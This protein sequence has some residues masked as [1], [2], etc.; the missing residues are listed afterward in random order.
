[1]KTIV[2]ILLIT[3]PFNIF[4]QELDINPLKKHKKTLIGLNFSP[5][6]S[7]RYLTGGSSYWTDSRNSNENPNFNFAL[8]LNI[9]HQIHHNIDL[10]F[11]VQYSKNGYSSD[12]RPL[13]FGDLLGNGFIIEDSHS[14]SNGKFT[15][16]YNYL[17]LPIRAIASFGKKKINFLA[18][19]GFTT[20]I[21]INATSETIIKYSNNQTERILIDYSG[22]RS[23]NISPIISVGAEYNVNNNL[24]LGIEPT[25]RYSLFS[26][27]ESSIEHLYNYGVNMSLYYKLK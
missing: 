12:F 19:L 4:S 5:N 22:L 11:G 16:N 2:F 14:P 26:L 8:G 18:S 6:I 21:L 3:L 1:M 17:N 9:R 13:K 10:E 24:K 27:Y 25:F 23:I 20:D 15:D 7:Y